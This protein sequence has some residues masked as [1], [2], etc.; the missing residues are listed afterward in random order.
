[1]T[2]E[3]FSEDTNTIDDVL[4]SQ[5]LMIHEVIEISELKKKGKKI[6]KRV[7]VDSSRELIYNVHFTAMDHEL[8]FLR[9]QGNTDAYA[10]RLHAHYKVLTTDPN[11]PESMKPRAQEIWEKHR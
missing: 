3:I 9:R 8:D 10:K 2:G 6:D 4:A 5:N 1:M 7:I 11:L